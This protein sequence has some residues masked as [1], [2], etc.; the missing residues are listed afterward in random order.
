L[1]KNEAVEHEN[2]NENENQAETY[3]KKYIPNL[4]YD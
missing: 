2:E 1:V 3:N 4:L